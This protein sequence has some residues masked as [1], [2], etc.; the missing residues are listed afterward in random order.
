MFCCSS[1]SC[2]TLPIPV[3]ILSY[4]W[5]LRRVNCAFTFIHTL[6]VKVQPSRWR[7]PVPRAITI[8]PAWLPCMRIHLL[9][10]SIFVVLNFF[11]TVLL[12]G[13]P[14]TLVGPSLKTPRARSRWPHPQLGYRVELNKLLV[15]GTACTRT[16]SR[17]SPAKVWLWCRLL[18]CWC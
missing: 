4:S 10:H 16:K 3:A 9:H 18:R 5:R 1:L 11:N 8:I 14:A 6:P 12:A 13:L 15:N 2:F 17:L 7:N